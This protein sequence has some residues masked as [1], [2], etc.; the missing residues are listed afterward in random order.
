[1]PRPTQFGSLERL[2]D[3][4]QRRINADPFQKAPAVMNDGAAGVPL[5]W[6]LLGDTAALIC[7]SAAR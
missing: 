7:A 3:G 6:L 4:Y 1:M 5:H 2:S